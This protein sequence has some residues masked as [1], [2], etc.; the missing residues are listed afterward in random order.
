MV[1]IGVCQE[2]RDAGEGARTRVAVAWVDNATAA[3][4]YGGAT[5]GL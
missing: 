3:I 1:R 4:P 2:E 5:R